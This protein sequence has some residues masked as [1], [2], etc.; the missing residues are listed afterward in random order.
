M[1]FLNIQKD[2]EA[3]VYRDQLWELYEQ[4]FPPEEKKPRSLMEELAEQGKMELLVIVEQGEFVGLAMNMLAETGAL[5]D[6]FAIAKEKRSGGFGSRAVRMLQERFQ[7]TTYIFEIEM[8][9]PEAEN[10]R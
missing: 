8:Q 6:Y 4:A 7:G 2:K 10:A 3:L 1:E 9:D 5:L